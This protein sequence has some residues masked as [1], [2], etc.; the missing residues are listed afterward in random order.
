VLVT[1]FVVAVGDLIAHLLVLVAT[2]TFL[3]VLGTVI[4]FIWTVLL[5]RTNDAQRLYAEAALR[6]EQTDSPLTGAL[7]APITLRSGATMEVDLL[8]PYE[9]HDR[10]LNRTAPISWMDRVNPTA[11]AEALPLV[12]IGIWVAV[13]ISI[14]TWFLFFQ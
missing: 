8:H 10:R 7:P 2:V 4:S 3:A 14:W 1:G 13:A 12:F 6:L 11:L 9:A 5:H